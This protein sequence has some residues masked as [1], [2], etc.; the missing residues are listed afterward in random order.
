MFYYEE[1][2][3]D[4]ADG[5]NNPSA[6]YETFSVFDSLNSIDADADAEQMYSYWFESIF[7]ASNE[8]YTYTGYDIETTSEYKEI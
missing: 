8:Y 5:V 6:V 4:I 2:Q 1:D 3:Y 7:I